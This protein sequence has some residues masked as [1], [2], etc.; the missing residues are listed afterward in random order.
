MKITEETSFILLFEIFVRGKGTHLTL[1]FLH[2]QDRVTF[3]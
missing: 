3:L 2:F 1:I